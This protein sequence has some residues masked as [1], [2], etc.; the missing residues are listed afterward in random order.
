MLHG[1]QRGLV[2]LSHC[3]SDRIVHATG[4][5]RVRLEP[6]VRACV[7]SRRSDAVVEHKRAGRGRYAEI[8]GF[9]G[10]ADGTGV[11]GGNGAEARGKSAEDR[12]SD[13]ATKAGG[14][15]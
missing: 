2:D 13:E 1:G 10:N 7:F 9:H 6:I 4:L 15:G 11:S 3:V 5:S 14:S 8:S 12:G